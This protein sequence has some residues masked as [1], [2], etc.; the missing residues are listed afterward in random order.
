MTR[1]ANSSAIILKPNS[2]FWDW[3][4]GDEVLAKFSKQDRDKL[5][6]TNLEFVRANATV[7]A[8]PLLKDEALD[9]AEAYIAS[10]ADEILQT[11]FQ[12]WGINASLKPSDSAMELL[13]RWFDISHHRRIYYI[14]K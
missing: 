1:I 10:H 13:A 12:R 5:N 11:E 14:E 7:I 6:E 4:H 3:V 2:V 9:E 8:I